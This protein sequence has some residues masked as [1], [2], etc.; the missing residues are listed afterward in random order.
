MPRLSMPLPLPL[1]AD[2]EVSGADVGKDEGLNVAT[3]IGSQKKKTIIVQLPVSKSTRKFAMNL[4]VTFLH[5]KI[6]IF[7]STC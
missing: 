4:T 1:A 3:G 7:Y 2:E 5:V 6:R